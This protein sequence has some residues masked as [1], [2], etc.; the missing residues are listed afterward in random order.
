MKDT[1]T[2]STPDGRAT[3][4]ALENAIVKK[5]A[6][7]NRGEKAIVSLAVRVK[8]GA[9]VDTIR[10][11]AERLTR[12]LRGVTLLVEEGFPSPLVG[13]IGAIATAAADLS[14]HVPRLK[15]RTANRLNDSPLDE[16]QQLDLLL[17]IALE[18]MRLRLPPVSQ[19]ENP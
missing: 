19:R 7:L 12:D 18:N 13:R 16:D 2:Y 9:P 10:K 11:D 5:N 6:G 17:L 1:V 14:D 4:A 8:Y 3:L 15:H